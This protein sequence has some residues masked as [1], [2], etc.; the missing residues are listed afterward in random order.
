MYLLFRDV[1]FKNLEQDTIEKFGSNVDN[2]EKSDTTYVN[3][4]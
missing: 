3:K 1:F 2:G 4:N